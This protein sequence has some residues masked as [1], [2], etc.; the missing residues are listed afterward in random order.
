M[1]EH[2]VDPDPIV[3]TALELLPVPGHRDDFW[4]RLTEAIDAEDPTGVPAPSDRPA[5][6]ATAAV[7]GPLG[8]APLLERHPSSALVPVALRRPSNVALLAVA[9]LAAVVVG[10]AGGSLLRGRDGTG[11]L[12]SGDGSPGAELEA[13]VDGAQGGASVLEP[14]A[15]ADATSARD[16]VQAWLG[17]VR[18]GDSTLAWAAMGPASKAHFGSQAA[19]AEEMPAMAD[20]MGS[21]ANA[22]PDQVLVTPVTAD[23]EG[24][25]VVVTL[26]GTVARDG[27]P[28]P[29]ADAFPVR[30]T[31]G[32]ARL[33]P[34]ASAGP[35]ELVVP[36]AI[37]GDHADEPVGTSEDL[38]VVLP[39]GVDAPVVRID[40]GDTLICGDAD[41]T[42]LIPLAEV[43]GQRCS[44]LPDGGLT[45]GSHVLTVAFRGAEGASWSVASVRFDVA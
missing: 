40:D 30:L 19:F 26:V 31:D 44:Y 39:S 18:E 3:Q 42:E 9:A 21:W 35:I 23:D 17:A 10:L 38:V 37:R 7:D 4:A 27:E 29:R 12:T 11:R 15:R 16:A 20:G 43:P 2:V 24:T 28:T 45:S 14:V 13:L 5:A 36:E 22:R 1:S 41:G 6:I 33:E 34:Y 8:A 25:L 32:Q